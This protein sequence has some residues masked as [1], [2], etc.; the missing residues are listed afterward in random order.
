MSRRYLEDFAVGQQFS[1]TDE[2]EMRLEEMT[3]FAGTYDPQPIHLDPVLAA[4]EMFAGLVASG[5]HTLAATTRLVLS[6]RPLGD[7]PLVGVAIDRLRFLAPV[8]A[9]DVLTADATVLD[10]RQSRSHPERGYL[11]L[12]VVT[13]RRSGAQPVLTQDWTLLV[14]ARTA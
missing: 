8:R 6:A 3:A 9:G 10:V 5:W 14:P 1:A 13:S 11:V 4:G 7:T 12:R 2:Y